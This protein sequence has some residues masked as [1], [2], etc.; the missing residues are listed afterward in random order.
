MILAWLPSKTI[1]I[2]PIKLIFSG[3]A[4]IIS[5]KNGQGKPICLKRFSCW[6]RLVPSGLRRSAMSSMG[7]N[8][9]RLDGEVERHEKAVCLDIQ[10]L[11]STKKLRI[12]QK[13]RDIFDY[14]GHLNAQ[15]FSS[16]QLE[17]FRSEAEQRRKFVDGTLLAAAPSSETDGG[18]HACVKQKNS[19]LRIPVPYIISSLVICLKS[20][21]RVAE[22]G[23]RIIASRS[24][25]VEKSGKPLIAGRI[26]GSE[27][28]NIQYHP[29]NEISSASDVNGVQSQLITK[30]RLIAKRFVSSDHWSVLIGMRSRFSSMARRCNDFRLPGNRER[31]VGLSSGTNGSSPWP[32]WRVSDFSH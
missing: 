20:G 18:L 12:N 17:R 32:S 4:N 10:Q 6:P 25:Y 2:Y 15:V 7:D 9:F 30:S 14:I 11:E 24:G 21:I 27:S 28:V 26:I 13:P 5:G 23:A 16:N 31:V 29:C 22:L 8:G 3:Q 19:L 1:E